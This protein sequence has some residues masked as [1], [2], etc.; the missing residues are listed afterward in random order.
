MRKLALTAAFL[1]VLGATAPALAQ[2]PERWVVVGMQGGAMGWD[3][4]TIDEDELMG[5]TYL[6]RLVYFADSRQWDGHDYHY[7]RQDIGFK[8]KERKFQIASILFMEDDGFI[9]GSGVP[10][11]DIWEPVEAAT[12]EGVL[13]AAICDKAEILHTHIYDDFDAA[14]A[15]TKALALPR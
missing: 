7:E 13:W 8:C 1:A 11:E 6:S 15:A 2:E 10:E 12:P 4:S 3:T 9:F 5:G 14:F